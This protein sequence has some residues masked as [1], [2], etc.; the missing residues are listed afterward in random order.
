MSNGT[1]R[2]AGAS[3]RSGDHLLCSTEGKVRHLVLNRPDRLNALSVALQHDLVEQFLL[4]DEDPG[5]SAIVLSATGDRAFC[6][7]IDVKDVAEDPAGF[8]GPIRQR[9]R[10]V[11]EVVSQTCKP[12]IAALNG[13]T[14][15][16]GF[17]LALACDLIVAV[18]G[19]T[20]GL[21]E[22]RRGMG[23]AF[24]S[25]MLPRRLPWGVAAEMLF[26]GDWID[27][28]RAHHF[29]L[30]N[31]VVESSD[32]ERV[33]AQ[34][35]DKIAANAPLS[36]RRM[37]ETAVKTATLPVVAAL[38]LDVGPNLYVSEDVR[39]G[40]TAFLEKRPPKWKGR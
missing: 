37:K 1:W 7:G 8:R 20:L 6:A 27:V 17:E 23:A 16:G 30:V 9:S 31:R 39:E 15:G 4:A 21:P 13:A 28:D 35:A 26:T 3:A 25:V 22:A 11:W 29:G 19:I 14:V 24:G 10:M 34:L 32:L 2:S 36:L 12:T 33:T 18:R 38:H 5:I 40:V